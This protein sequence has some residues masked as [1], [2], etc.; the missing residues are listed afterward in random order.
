MNYTEEQ[1]LYYEEPQQYNKED[2]QQDFIPA[3][4]LDLD[5]KDYNLY[6]SF[7]VNNIP[8]RKIQKVSAIINEKAAELSLR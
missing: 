2:F 4:L 1:H 3:T 5:N 7:T 8:V 6:S